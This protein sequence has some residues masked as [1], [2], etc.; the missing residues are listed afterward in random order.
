VGRRIG[1]GENTSFWSDHW[2]EGWVLRDRFR[3]LFELSLDPDVSVLVMR[4]D[5]WEVDGLEVEKKTIC[6]GGG[7]IDR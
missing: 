3:C 5:G 7:T 1:N 4:R 2:L 6:M